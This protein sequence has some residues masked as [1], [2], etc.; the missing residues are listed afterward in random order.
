[1]LRIFTKSTFY[2]VSALL[3]VGGFSGAQAQANSQVADMSNPSLKLPQLPEGGGQFALVRA[4]QQRVTYPRYALRNMIQGQC[5]VSFA[6]APDGQVRR[7]R[8]LRSLQADIDT[9][10]VQAVRQLPRL[11]PATQDGKVVACLMTAPVTFTIDNV[12]LNTKKMMQPA[13]STQLYTALR[14]MPYYLGHPG[15]SRLAAD[16]VTEYSRLR[17]GLDCAIPRLN[18]GVLVTIGPNGN[19]YDF[20]LIKSNEQDYNALRMEYGDAVA[21][22]EEAEMSAACLTL[23][24]QAAQHLP[25]LSPAYAD[26]KRVATR[27]QLTLQAPAN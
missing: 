27:L 1:M 26:G 7:V 21:H 24:A 12:P 14:Q 6:V 16:L 18:L 11:I 13:D 8:I 4:I 23:L 10:V 2:W 17:N 19:L 15:Y 5:Q 22:G 3:W 25:R 9:A 20:Q